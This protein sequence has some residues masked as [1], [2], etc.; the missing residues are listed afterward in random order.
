LADNDISSRQGEMPKCAANWSWKYF[1]AKLP[2]LFRH[3]LQQIFTAKKHCPF[4]PIY[5][6]E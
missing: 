1:S 6:P 3:Q 4:H 5:F 2:A